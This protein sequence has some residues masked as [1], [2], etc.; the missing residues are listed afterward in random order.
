M[1]SE[2]VQTYSIRWQ[3]IKIEI[4]CRTRWLGSPYSH[5]EVRAADPPNAPLPITET[6][7]LSYYFHPSEIEDG[8]NIPEAVRL[9]LDNEAQSD[10]WKT[11]L[12]E[13]RQL[14]LF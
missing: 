2:A 11:F 8:L 9:W 5:L 14:S 1:S 7:Y 10:E 4:T 3:G 6:G 13:N 12:E